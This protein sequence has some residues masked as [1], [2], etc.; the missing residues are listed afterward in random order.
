MGLITLFINYGLI[1]SLFR[2]IGGALY[3]CW[4]C[5]GEVRSF[6]KFYYVMLKFW[7]SSCFMR[8]SRARF[9]FLSWINSVYT[10]STVVTFGVMFCKWVP[11]NLPYSVLLFS[12][13]FLIWADTSS[14]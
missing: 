10:S 9:L 1:G 12:M 7:F 2:L 4:L 14:S 13:M 3:C 6:V 11:P 5:W 8:P